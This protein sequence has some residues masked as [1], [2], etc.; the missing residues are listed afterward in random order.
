MFEMNKKSLNDYT[1]KEIYM[2]FPF[3]EEEF[4]SIINAQELRV[5]ADNNYNKFYSQLKLIKALNEYR[6]SLYLVPGMHRYA[7]G[8]VDRILDSVN[9]VKTLEIE[10]D[11]VYN[12]KSGEM[13][14]SISSSEALI[15]DELMEQFTKIALKDVHTKY[16]GDFGDIVE[17]DGFDKARIEYIGNE[18]K[19]IRRSMQYTNG[20]TELKM[21][22]SQ[23][24]QIFESLVK[25]FGEERM[26]T[27]NSSNM[28]ELSKEFHECG[29]FLD[30]FM[31]N[32]NE[33]N[34]IDLPS[35]YREDVRL[36]LN[37]DLLFIERDQKQILSYQK[38]QSKKA[39]GQVKAFKKILDLNKD[40]SP[41]LREQMYSNLLKNFKDFEYIDFDDDRW[42]GLY[43]D[44]ELKVSLRRNSNQN[45]DA[46]YKTILHELVHAATTTK[47]KM[48]RTQKIGFTK[49][50]G[51]VIEIG[52]QGLNEGATEYFAQKLYESTG[53][54]EVGTA[55]LSSVRVI[56][57]L[58]DLY[59][60]NV[61][62]DAMV[63]DTDNLKQLMA[64]DGKNYE[65][66]RWLMDEYYK[67]VYYND[68][69]LQPGEAATTAEAQQM[70]YKVQYFIQDI[71]DRRIIEKNDITDIQNEIYEY[72][73]GIQDRRNVEDKDISVQET[74]TRKD[75]KI[76][77]WFKNV[78]SKLGNIF[79]FNKKDKTLLLNASQSNLQIS[80]SSPVS[81]NS[82]QKKNDFRES[83]RVS[84]IDLI[85]KESN[86]KENKVGEKEVDER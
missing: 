59:G 15:F 86:S 13:F 80:D 43:H 73:L 82:T 40:I 10:K 72:V 3:F 33:M 66:L 23:N 50:G 45:V 49:M 34:K 2:N 11:L 42:T 64:K 5:L 46:K 21:Q 28:Q 61:I 37:N 65:E 35:D 29:V 84:E 4:S 27:L 19:N 77:A 70:Y 83:V 54:P 69:G 20:Y 26:L 7:D 53:R 14:F 68:K 17:C 22:G 12:P 41:E 71:K 52:G 79:S 44:D 31:E 9:S 30:G 67:Q 24:A 62:L 25:I 6:N 51:L 75:N 39:L 55:Y 32:L 85:K 38:A 63:N 58:V 74:E 76:I 78:K 81:E 57:R 36:E 56:E 1:I 16:K 8:M 48:G 60:E 18:L 47:D